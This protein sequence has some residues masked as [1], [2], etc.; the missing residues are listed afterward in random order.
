LSCS[1][2]QYTHEY[3][4]HYYERSNAHKN[5]ASYTEKSQTDMC[6][7]IHVT[8]HVSHTFEVCHTWLP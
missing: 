2:K 4:A 3:S 7:Y 6:F 5:S 1:D 8:Q